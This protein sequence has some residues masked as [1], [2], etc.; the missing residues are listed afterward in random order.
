MDRTAAAQADAAAELR[1]GE[2]SEIPQDPKEGCI[3]CAIEVAHPSADLNRR[4]DE[5]SLSE[6]M[7]AARAHDH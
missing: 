1:S 5:P 4:H 3:I 7:A 6:E 2:P